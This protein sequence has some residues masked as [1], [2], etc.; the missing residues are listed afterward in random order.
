MH[1]AFSSLA[2]TA[3]HKFL[4]ISHKVDNRLGLMGQI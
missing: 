3:K 1:V 2:A 4:P